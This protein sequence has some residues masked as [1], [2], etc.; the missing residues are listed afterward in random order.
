MPVR[1]GRAASSERP[2]CRA[3]AQWSTR[4]PAIRA[5]LSS[6]PP[7]HP[8]T[9]SQLQPRLT[10]ALLFRVPVAAARQTTRAEKKTR[11]KKRTRPS[12]SMHA[13]HSGADRHRCLCPSVWCPCIILVCVCVRIARGAVC[14]P[15]P[16]SQLPAS[17]PLRPSAT[18]PIESPA[19]SNS[20]RVTTTTLEQQREG[21]S[22][23]GWCYCRLLSRRPQSTG[24]S[25]RSCS[26]SPCAASIAS[27]SESTSRRCRCART[28][29]PRSIFIPLTISFPCSPRADHF[30]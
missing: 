1:L 8:R 29:V 20:T 6:T 28:L 21:G 23:T 7:S 3:A 13:G 9:S 16:F 22:C 10:S 27:P 11:K 17:S 15:N 4:P 2:Q 19:H 12:T 26:G 5:S 14:R 24:A 25:E 30:D 18:P